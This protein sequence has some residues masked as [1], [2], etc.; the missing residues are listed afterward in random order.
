MLMKEEE[1]KEEI[2]KRRKHER[3]KA[4]NYSFEDAEDLLDRDKEKLGRDVKNINKITK[5]VLGSSVDSNKRTK[6]SLE[7]IDEPSVTQASR[8]VNTSSNK[9][10]TTKQN[11]EPILN[12]NQ[13]NNYNINS[14]PG[15]DVALIKSE[16][17]LHSRSMTENQSC[18]KGH[19]SATIPLPKPRTFKR[20][21]NIPNRCNPAF[22]PEQW[23]FKSS[24]VQEQNLG[25]AL[26]CS[27]KFF[28]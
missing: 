1:T 23:K 26:T 7:V 21:E 3:M 22:S 14:N 8:D 10:K 18:L 25:S 15:E 13:I 28:S 6:S 5:K 20:T 12:K 17:P 2:K 27:S 11:M 19:H 9:L 24:R 4:L 16:T